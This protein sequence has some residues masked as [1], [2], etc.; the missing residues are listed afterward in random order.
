MC[1][2]RPATSVIDP[3]GVFRP[4]REALGDLVLAS[5]EVEE[6]LQDGIWTLGGALENDDKYQVATSTLG[7]L[8]N[9]FEKQY[10]MQSASVAGAD[11]IAPLC[12]RLRDLSRERNDLIHGMWTFDSDEGV[13]RR[14]RVRKD[15]GGLDL[16][17]QAVSVDQVLDLASRFR[18]AG[19]KLWEILLHLEDLTR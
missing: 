8:V 19:D 10:A 5:S 3:E 17:I 6:T 2:V 16:N 9:K 4:W 7:W 13:A 11:P 18:N 14:H 1:R 12:E 15:G